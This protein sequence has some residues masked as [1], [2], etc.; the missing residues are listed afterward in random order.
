M[1]L[2]VGILPFSIVL[3]PGMN[4]L[5]HS[6]FYD[7]SFFSLTDCEWLYNRQL[8]TRRRVLFR[9]F[10]YL[11]YTLIKLYYTKAL[12]DS[13]SS[14]APDWIRLLWR[15]RIPHLIFQQQ[16][17]TSFL[18]STKPL[19]LLYFL[20][21]FTYWDTASIFPRP[22]ISSWFPSLTLL[23]E[24]SLGLRFPGFG[25]LSP[26]LPPLLVYILSPPMSHPLVQ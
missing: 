24:V 21:Q 23:H 3:W 19:L 16:P 6:K 25:V 1:K 4:Y 8:K 26:F 13:A 18:A 11:L 7:I 15:P 2:F 17:F 10:L 12:S 22:E 5:V 14:L 20:S 9:S